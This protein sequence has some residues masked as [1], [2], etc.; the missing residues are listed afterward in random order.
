MNNQEDTRLENIYRTKQN[1]YKKLSIGRILIHLFFIIYSLCCVIPILIVIS[2]SLSTELDI[3]RDGYGLW[4]KGFTT[5]AYKTVLKNPV[6][7][8]RSYAV[9][10]LVSLAGVVIGLWLTSTIAYVMSRK[11]FF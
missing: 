8:L 3:V 2:S 1:T 6:L 5:F 9:T 7:I 4:P 11:D 10:T